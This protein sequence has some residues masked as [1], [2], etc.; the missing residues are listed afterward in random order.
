[1]CWLFP[2]TDRLAILAASIFG[3][4]RSCLLFLQITTTSISPQSPQPHFISIHP[5]GIKDLNPSTNVAFMS[6]ELELGKLRLTVAKTELE[7]Q[8]TT[9]AVF[10]RSDSQDDT[11]A[12]P[13]LDLHTLE[14]NWVQRGRGLQ[15]QVKVLVEGKPLTP[16]LIQSP[17]NILCKAKVCTLSIRYSFFADPHSCGNNWASKHRQS[18]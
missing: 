16:A 9:T 14:R 1:M 6:A 2:H 15:L 7:V 18:P 12:P 3:Q 8:S 11:S 10:S 5:L 17:N 13:K 4:G